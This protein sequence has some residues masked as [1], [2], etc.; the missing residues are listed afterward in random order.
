LSC[1]TVATGNTG[2][3]AAD[4]FLVDAEAGGF[5]A[6]DETARGDLASADAAAAGGDVNAGAMRVKRR[7]SGTAGEMPPTELSVIS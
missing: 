5:L 3:A 7:C 2:T 6:D 4:F 1:A